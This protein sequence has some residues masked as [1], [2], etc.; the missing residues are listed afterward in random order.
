MKIKFVNHLWNEIGLKKVHPIICQTSISHW[1]VAFQSSGCTQ[2]LE[3][4]ACQSN[5]RTQPLEE[6]GKGQGVGHENDESYPCR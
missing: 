1:T 4:R 2:L 6:W 5:G 3:E